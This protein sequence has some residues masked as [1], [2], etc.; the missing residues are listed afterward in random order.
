MSPTATIKLFLVNG[1]PQ[2]LR[3]VEISNWTGK[4]V[5]GP[6]TEFDELLS[7][8]EAL[9]S[10]VSFLT[11]TDAETGKDAV[12]IGE[13][14][15]VRDRL[16]IHLDKD[17]WNAATFLISK[18]ENLTKAHIRYLE[19]RLIEQAKSAGRALVMNGQ[20]SGARLPESDR[21]DMEVFLA[22]IHQIMPVLGHNFLVPLVGATPKSN[23]NPTLYCRIKGLTARGVRA[24]AGF[25]VLQGSQ[26]VLADRQSSDYA[27]KLRERLIADG[28]LIAR[29]SFYEFAR[30]AEFTSPSAAA[31]VIHGGNVNG[32]VHWKTEEG[33]SLKELEE[34]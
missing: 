26:A 15:V 12:Y 32:L 17:Y 5:S 28:T 20:S 25:L 16:K 18:D 7:R 3:T 2:R 6:R 33:K 14:E 1:D 8:E 9:N 22:R 21:Q 29:E 13:A 4:A 11:G 30:N 24:V 34:I 27:R 19:G 10:G 23:Q 31:A